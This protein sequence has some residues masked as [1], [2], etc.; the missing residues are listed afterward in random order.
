M[1]FGSLTCR[2]AIAAGLFGLARGAMLAA[3]L[4]LLVPLLMTAIPLDPQL[5]AA[6]L[7]E[8]M[9]RSG[10]DGIYYSKSFA[11]TI[12]AMQRDARVRITQY[13]PIEEVYDLV[14]EDLVK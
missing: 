8:L 3:L 10:C 4:F 5:T 6:E 2:D 12:A 7:T 14:I 11:E 1:F 13:I 9:V